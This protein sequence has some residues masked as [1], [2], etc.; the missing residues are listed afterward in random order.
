[1]IRQSNYLFDKRNRLAGFTLIEMLT[2]VAILVVISALSYPFF[3]RL[4]LQNFVN[5]TANNLVGNLRRAQ[6]YAMTSKDSS[7]WQVNYSNSKVTLVESGNG[8]V[9]GT[10]TISPG[11]SVTG[12]SQIIFSNPTG[13][14]SNTG[15]FTVVDGNITETVTID[16]QGVASASQY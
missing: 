13:L 12:P 4:I 14:P 6:F 11:V 10:Y 5:D 3:T 2:V 15:T 16:S 9:F 7:N 8:T 1:M